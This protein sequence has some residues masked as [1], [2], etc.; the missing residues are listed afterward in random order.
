MLQRPLA[1][2][3]HQRRVSAADVDVLRD[4]VVGVE[5]AHKHVAA[6]QPAR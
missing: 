6:I 5:L 3:I 2:G 1:N 4:V